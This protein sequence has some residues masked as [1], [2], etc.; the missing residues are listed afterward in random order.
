MSV[1]YFDGVLNK[2]PLGVHAWRQADCLSLTQQYAEGSS[3]LEPEMHILLADDYT[4]GKSAGEFPI[5]YYSVGKIW[6]A[7]GQSYLSYRLFYLLITLIALFLLYKALLIALSDWFWAAFITLLVFT[8]PNFVAYST[9]FLTDAPSICFVFIAFYFLTR[10]ATAR[11][12]KWFYFS[13][14]F[15]ALAGL[16]KTSSLIAFVFLLFIFAVERL[17]VK[18]LGDRKLFSRPIAEG[19]GFAGA[20]L[21]IFS[22]YLY[23]DYY[24]GIHHF[25]YTFNSI[26]PMW[27]VPSA[28]LNNILEGLKNSTSQSFFSRAVLFAFLFLGI[29]NIFLYKRI[30]FFAYSASLIIGIGCIAYF[31]LWFPLMENH[32]YYF[33]ILV[34]LVP[35]IFTPF[36]L[37]IKNGNPAIFTGRLTRVFLSIFLLFNFL[38]SS[39][40]VQLSL[41]GRDKTYPFIGNYEFIKG[42]RYMVW[43]ADNEWR[44]FERMQ[45]YLLDIGVSEDDKVVSMPDPSFNVSL[46]YADRR[47]WTNFKHIDT[48]EMNKMI[49]KGAKYLFV[50]NENTLSEEFLQPFLKNQIG[51]FEGIKIFKLPDSVEPTASIRELQLK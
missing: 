11:H 41:K 15:F 35:A 3:F 8:S 20:I 17:P 38:Y 4:T 40:V 43:S 6:S 32:N 1:I 19:L 45:P 39:E 13:M 23:A 46:F 16:I 24:N 51:E 37:F 18:S 48:E 44:R 31:T 28:K 50:S 47:G 30:N 14:A 9:S 21:L 22:W 36:A 26:Y 34:I 33:V 5:M 29:F 12:L 49:S 42:M 7:L 2:G 27:E 25:K 10:Y